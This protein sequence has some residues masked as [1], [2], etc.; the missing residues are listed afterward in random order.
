MIRNVL[1]DLDGTLT[2]PKDGITRCIQ[3]SLGRLGRDAPSSDELLWCIGPP[4]RQSFSC[5]LENHDKRLLDLALQYYRERFSEIGIYENFVYPGIATALQK[6]YK[7]GFRL[8]LATSKPKVYATRI[9]DHFQLTQLFHGIYGSE[10]DGNLVEKADLIAHVLKSEHLERQET[11]MVGDRLHDVIG[12]KQNGIATAAVTYGYG[13]RN[14]IEDARPDFIFHSPSD[15]A[16]Y[17]V[18]TIQ[19][20]LPYDRLRSR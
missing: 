18:R 3:F 12:G 4:L 5:L 17:L 11:L 7:A 20:D 2:D 10:L 19:L 9:L 14:E 1:F 8:F 15:L 13:T 6:I 16:A